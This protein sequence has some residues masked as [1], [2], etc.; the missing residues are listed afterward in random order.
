MDSLDANDPI[1]WRPHG[2]YLSGSNLCRFMDRHRIGDLAELVRHSVED[3]EWFWTA[4]L[5]DIN[6]EWYAPFERL[7]D[8]SRGLPW[9][10]WFLSGRLNIVHNC[11][12]RHARRSPGSLALIW[13]GED[14]EVRR[15]TYSQLSLETDRVAAALVQL[16]IGR[17]DAVGFYMPMVPELIAS[18]FAVLKLGAVAVP[19]FSAFGPEALAVRLRDAEAKILFTADGGYRRGQPVP[20]KA[21]A[22]A[23]LATV[24][25]VERVIVLKRTGAAL[26]WNGG[27]DLW[28]SDF[29]GRSSGPAAT[30]AMDPEDPCLIIYT[31]SS[32]FPPVS[33]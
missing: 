20:V 33:S 13:E 3:I 5:E 15:F 28:W 29:I 17:G 24:P 9:C 21:S 19:V 4:A 10:R 8:D 14:G 11:L 7:L 6:I 2:D 25:S 23:A 26:D 30:V 31:G 22:D 12:D 1:I 32:S 18:F 27:R 16:G